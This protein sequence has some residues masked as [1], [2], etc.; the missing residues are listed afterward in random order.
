MDKVCEML[1]S[2]FY[3]VPSLD[4]NTCSKTTSPSALVSRAG[5]KGK[6]EPCEK[7]SS[8][9]SSVASYWRHMRNN[10]QIAN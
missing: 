3:A 5:G 10:L 9:N 6:Y 2:D 1:P 4:L 8:E 7:S